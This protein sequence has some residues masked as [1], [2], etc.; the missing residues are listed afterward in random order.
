MELAVSKLYLTE[1][2][3]QFWGKF[4]NEGSNI[5]ALTNKMQNFIAEICRVSL[6]RLP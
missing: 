6:L 5:L 4:I 1:I 2:R 3:K